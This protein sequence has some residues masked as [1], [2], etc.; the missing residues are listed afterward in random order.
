MHRNIAWDPASPAYEDFLGESNMYAGLAA[1][2]LSRVRDVLKD[3]HYGCAVCTGR[4]VTAG[5]LLLAAVENDLDPGLLFSR[6]DDLLGGLDDIAGLDPHG[7]RDSDE[8]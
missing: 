4:E 5:E 2:A 1:L 7:I 6:A 3:P 8:F